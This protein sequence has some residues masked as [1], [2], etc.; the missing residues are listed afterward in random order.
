MGRC[1][2]NAL[3]YDTVETDRHTVEIRKR[4][5][6][7]SQRVDELLGCARVVR[8]HADAVRDE[9][10]GRVEH[11][12]LQAGAADV[13]RQASSVSTGARRRARLDLR[14]SSGWP[15][16][17]LAD[18]WDRA[19]T[20]FV[21]GF[22]APVATVLASR[23]PAA[24]TGAGR[25]GAPHCLAGVVPWGH[26]TTS[27]PAAPVAGELS[28]SYEHR[29]SS[30]VRTPKPVEPLRNSPASS[31]E[32]EGPAMSRWAQGRS[33]T[34]SWSR[35]AAVRVP[36]PALALVLHVGDFGVDVARYVSGSGSGQV[37][38]PARSDAA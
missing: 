24:P 5:D 37:G 15:R 30:S 22:T 20:R 10:A 1:Q 12:S 16:S 36:P 29:S 33:A 7:P 28:G 9:L 3:A 17:R 4:R 21:A 13:D 38:S 27:P 32:R 18:V 23:G 35:R 19:A 8:G 26:G 2:D 34:N 14:L 6:K 11:R 31:S 25:P